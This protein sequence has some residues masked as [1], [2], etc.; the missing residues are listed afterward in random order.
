[1]THEST[2]PITVR[3][4][5]W[6]GALLAAI[7]L[8][9]APVS[10]SAGT[11]GWARFGHFAP[12]AAAVDVFVDGSLFV[13]DVGFKAVSD[14]GSLP[15]GPHMFE[16][17]AAGAPDS[18]PV[19]SIQADVP[20]DG[21][22]TVGAVTS[23]DQVTPQ[24]YTDELMTPDAGAS[25]VRFIHA[26]PD[27]AAVDIAV[28]GGD[29]IVSG[30]PYPEASA[31]TAVQPGTYDVIITD[32]DTGATV[33]EVAGWSI[34][35]GQQSTIVILRGAD[36]ALDVAPVVDAV[37]QPVAP[38]GGVQTGFGG[39]ATDPTGPSTW[40]IIAVSVAVMSFMG[41]GLAGVRRRT[42]VRRV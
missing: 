42:Q 30:V 1:M 7:V 36:G 17:R 35:A 8:L 20:A 13:S 21:A 22:I 10:A 23:L 4:G 11:T 39:M 15:A 31:Y 33:L 37:A 12:S 34:T 14:Y 3:I 6:I 40:P 18:A 16:V 26:A 24:V 27:A 28:R 41:A 25:L 9:A 2:T 5:A 29:P 19:V 38:V 32:S